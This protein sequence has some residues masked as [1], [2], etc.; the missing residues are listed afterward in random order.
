MIQEDTLFIY[1]GY[2]TFK[3]TEKLVGLIE[4]HLYIIPSKLIRKRI[5]NIAVEMIQNIDHYNKTISRQEL[6][7]NPGKFLIRRVKNK[8][9]IIVSNYIRSTDTAKLKTL[10]D[11][12]RGMNEEVL[13]QERY[14]RLSNI[15][16]N[17]P[18]ASIGI[19]SIAQR[20]NQNMN[21]KFIDVNG[22]QYFILKAIV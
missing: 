8:F 21:Y 13:T 2:F 4:Y 1:Q 12:I 16:N 10:L 22:S 3:L 17:V 19:L 5:F 7:E 14:K 9:E 15:E 20:T 18:S 6:L 11:E